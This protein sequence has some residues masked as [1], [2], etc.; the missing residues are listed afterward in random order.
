VQ[1]L[2]SVYSDVADEDGLRAYAREQCLLGFDGMGCIHPRQIRVI[3]DAF[4]PDAADV[5]KAQRIVA[6]FD[7]AAAAG[8]GVVALGSKMIDAPVVAR[9]Q[10]TLELAR[11]AGRL[12]E[13]VERDAGYGSD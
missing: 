6:A 9:A 7:E 8:R 2:A 11:L 1:P 12:P 4:T 13:T 10:R 5:Q 3:H